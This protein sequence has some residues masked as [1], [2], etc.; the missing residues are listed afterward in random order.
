MTGARSMIDGAAHST[1]ARR[2]VF[3][4]PAVVERPSQRIHDAPQQAFADRHIQ[5]AVGA[6]HLGAR[7]DAGAVVQQ[8]DADVV[9]D[10]D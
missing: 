9:R 5:D 10:R 3:D 7:F 1:G 2:C 6:P 4:R 8:N